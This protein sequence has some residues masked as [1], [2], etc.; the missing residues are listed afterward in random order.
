MTGG[1]AIADL[2]YSD[3]EHFGN[4]Q[5]FAASSSGTTAGI[6][7]GLGGSYALSSKWSVKAEYLYVYFGSTTY[8]SVGT[9]SPQNTMENHHSFY[10]Q[11]ARLGADYRF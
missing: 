3:F 2:Q 7:A 9:V 1:L 10:E 6:A 8:A 4:G 5:I 11:I